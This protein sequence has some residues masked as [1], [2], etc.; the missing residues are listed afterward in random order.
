MEI[1]MLSPLASPPSPLDDKLSCSPRV[2]KMSGELSAYCFFSFIFSKASLPWGLLTLR[3]RAPHIQN[4]RREEVRAADYPRSATALGRR[5]PQPRAVP[6]P[7]HL[8]NHGQRQRRATLQDH[9]QRPAGTPRSA[10]ARLLPSFRTADSSTD[11]DGL[12]S[13]GH[14]P[15]VS[16]ACVPSSAPFPKPWDT[17]EEEEGDRLCAWCGVLAQNMLHPG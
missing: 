3:E 4:W 15:A 11:P 9:G 13:P 5:G 1:P 2:W 8:Q 17:P 14:Q 6:A 10:L 16:H 12:C 7:G